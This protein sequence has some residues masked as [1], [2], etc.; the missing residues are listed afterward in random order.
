[1]SKGLWFL[2]FA[3]LSL[4]VAFS[5]RPGIERRASDRNF[6]QWYGLPGK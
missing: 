6:R 4:G 5:V 3:G 2:V 1:M